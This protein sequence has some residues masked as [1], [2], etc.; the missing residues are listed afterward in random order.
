MKGLLLFYMFL[1]F[2]HVADYKNMGL[3]KIDYY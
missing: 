1:Q 3:R 2:K